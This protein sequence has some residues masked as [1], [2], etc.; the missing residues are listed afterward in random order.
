[1]AW[2]AFLPLLHRS[3]RLRLDKLLR[4][5]TPETAERDRHGGGYQKPA[6]TVRLPG[7][8][9]PPAVDQRYPPRRSRSWHGEPPDEV[10]CRSWGPVGLR[11]QG[12]AGPGGLCRLGLWNGI[13]VMCLLPVARRYGVRLP[14]G[15]KVGCPVTGLRMPAGRPHVAIEVPRSVTLLRPVPASVLLDGLDAVVRP[16]ALDQHA[17][18]FSFPAGVLRSRRTPSQGG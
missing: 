14:P 15:T 3:V 17:R 10:R 9:T 5:A 1:M 13:L 16:R 8:K 11:P 4:S 18:R 2:Q 7:P 12:G 6:R